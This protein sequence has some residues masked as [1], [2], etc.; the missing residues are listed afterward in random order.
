MKN[1][2]LFLGSLFLS[3][4]LSFAQYSS[5]TGLTAQQLAELLAG[6]NVT[7]F[8]A[9]ITGANNAR[10][11]F[12]APNTNLGLNGG[13]VLTTGAINTLGGPN[14]MN[15]TTTDHGLP[16]TAQMTTIAGVQ[17]YDAVS[18]QFDFTVQTNSI[19]FEYVFGSEEYPDF[20]GGSYNDV[21]AFFISGPGITGEENIALIPNTNDPVTINNINANSYW[22]Y[23]IDNAGGTT[24]EL[25]AFTSVLKAKKTNL[26]P[27][28]TYT[29]KMVIADAGDGA[30]D[31]GV[32]LKE[33]SL[34][35]GKISAIASTVTDD[36]TSIEGCTRASF[37]F[38]L[39]EA[40]NE[41]T[42]VRFGIGGNA[43]NGVDYAYIDSVFVIPKG[44]TSATIYI[45][46][47]A[48]GI[49]EGQETVEL[50]FY[51]IPCSDPDTVFIYIED[52][53]PIDFL[54]NVTDLT[55]FGNQTGQIEVDIT[56]GNAPYSIDVIDENGF[57][58]NYTTT[59]ITGLNAG[60]YTIEVDDLYGCGGSAIVVGAQYDAGQT[61]LPDG[62]G[63]VFETTLSITDFPAGQTLTTLSQFQSVCL[64]M[65]H[66]FLGDLEI[67]LIAPNGNEVIL[68][69]RP[70]GGSCNLGEPVA[71]GPVDG[72][73]S[74]ITPGVGYEYCFTQNPTYGTMVSEINNYT[75]SYVDATGR[76]LTDKYLPQG[77]YES[78]ETLNNLLGS[79]LNGDWTIW[80]KDH[81]PQDN[82]YIFYW[83]ISFATDRLG[84]IAI[85]NQPDEI[86]V[87]ASASQAACASN[88][89]A[90]DINVVGDNPPFSYLWSTGATTQDITGLSAAAYSV[91]VSDVNSCTSSNIFVVENVNASTLSLSKTD[92]TCDGLNNGTIT[93]T[94]TGGETPYSYSWSN[95]LNTPS[96]SNLAAGTYSLTLSDNNNC[97]AIAVGQ[98]EN[99][100]PIFITNSILENE[101]CGKKDGTIGVTIFGGQQPYS[102]AW[103]NGANSS[104]NNY[105]QAGTYSVTV[106][107]NLGCAKSETYSIINEVSNCVINCNLSLQTVA[108]INEN[109]GNGQGSIDINPVNGTQPYLY[110]WS[111]GVTNQDLY[112]LNQ[113]QYNVTITDVNNCKVEE[114]YQ[115]D[116][117][118]GNISLSLSVTNETC[119]NGQGSVEANVAG[120]AMPYQYN[121][122]NG[123]TNNTVSGL[124]AN[125]YSLTF[126]DANGCSL[127][128][129]A[130]VLNDAGTL[131]Q[132]YG[133]AMNEV[134]GNA[135]G[136]IDIRIVGGSGFYFYNWSNGATSEDLINI[137]AGNY[138][139]TVTD[140][141]GCKVMTPVYE[142]LNE[143][144]T[145]EIYDITTFNEV[146][147]NQSG[148]ISL[149]IVGG[150]V[151]YTFSWSNGGNTSVIENLSAGNYSCLISDNTGCSV[152]TGN[153][154]ILNS[155]GNLILSGVDVTH[156]L[157]G[158]G[159][160]Q[161]QTFVSGGT[162]PY[163]FIWNNGYNTQN[164]ASLSAGTY[165]S[166][167]TDADGCSVVASGVVQ[168]QQGNL[169]VTN[170][171]VT[172]EICGNGE[173]SIDIFIS[174]G[175]APISYQW[176]NG[177]TSQDITNL[178]AGIYQC[179]IT[180]MMGCQT[181]TSA[182]INNITTGLS[183][184]NIAVTNE[185]CSNSSGSI[186]ITIVGG[187]TPY[188][189][190]WSN[191]ATTQDI[192]NLSAGTYSSTITDN[193]GCKVNVAPTTINNSA[194]GISIQSAIITDE[195][196]TNTQ[197][198]IDLTISASGSVNYLWSN[199]ATTEDI[200]GLSAGS[201]T[202]TISS[203]TGCE[204]VRN[205]LVNNQSGH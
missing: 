123:N 38:Y 184:S 132:N 92:I 3:F 198:S 173:G 140:G 18:F 11:K 104:Q 194:I 102:Y 153:I 180:D 103:S 55:C 167:I 170:A 164:I 160:G 31:S 69:E 115:I 83:N 179:L 130:E 91:T 117:E 156:E 80:V 100:T 190:M 171:I 43:V 90:I 185:V 44:Q 63:N 182:Q 49:P 66:S 93:S 89:G 15:G 64:N 114:S 181:A 10:G 187:N 193:S 86:E 78:Y 120:G 131:A 143:S 151:P 205:Y 84:N 150:N 85:V 76:S 33:N 169:T 202:I 56:G 191:G 16:G 81:K 149:D 145:L 41:P 26:I 35:Q 127:V 28:E 58:M 122:S 8:N 144:G 37:T 195:V 172:N 204:L 23:Y 136:S 88:D 20:V 40:K 22:Q 139:C 4:S 5:Q 147:N 39:D 183:V 105:L 54:A 128:R 203:G 24:I 21:F 197:G 118:V 36:N 9:S 162:I 57:R 116:N 45:N 175:T 155:S 13:V 196:C 138:Q 51:P 112:N 34:V 72:A 77:S 157:C 52:N 165:L 17:T 110:T 53:E 177:Q 101:K 95:S 189:Y 1:I 42:E 174:G 135:K 14:N 176:S 124:Y 109:C 121:W 59:T 107:D 152:N 137:S 98:I 50:Y 68:K 62:N 47:L 125:T 27:C 65:E 12:L 192:I 158:N 199:G 79:E 60:T 6:P 71:K 7:V 70:G 161:V 119:G 108:V 75:Y 48:D 30:Y 178:T 46:A 82:G 61:F 129:Q 94:A 87:T 113:G 2:S 200:V 73:N 111:N 148:R 19:E 163:S 96:I 106:T 134:C 141:F 146:C 154:E 25:N 99:N 188:T 186:D 32:F 126:T 159:Q 168:N 97:K 67:K 133:N 166:T 201:Y 29:L 142:V 74:D